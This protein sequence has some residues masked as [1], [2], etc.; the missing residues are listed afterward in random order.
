[1]SLDK[2]EAEVIKAQRIAVA[3]VEVGGEE[4]VVPVEVAGT[5]LT[6]AV[7]GLVKVFYNRGTS[8][9]RSVV[10]HVDIGDEHGERLGAVTKFGWGLLAG[11]CGVQHYP[12][13][14]S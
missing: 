1:M 5:V 14:A 11:V 4:P 10:V 3:S 2:F 9:F 8:R 12:G 7:G 13:G 6:L